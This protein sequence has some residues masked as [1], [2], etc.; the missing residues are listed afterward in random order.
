MAIKEDIK[1]MTFFLVFNNNVINLQVNVFTLNCTFF[2]N[3]DLYNFVFNSEVSSMGY[4][5]L[6]K[7]ENI[8]ISKTSG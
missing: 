8:S 4:I 2:P 7:K 6:I 5:I 1:R 3:L